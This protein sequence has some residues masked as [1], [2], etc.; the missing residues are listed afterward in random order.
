MKKKILDFIKKRGCVSITEL[1]GEFGVNN[2]L[3]GI[4]ELSNEGLVQMQD[5]IHVRA[6]KQ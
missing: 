3:D 2:A 1:Y 5:V 4:N 6:K